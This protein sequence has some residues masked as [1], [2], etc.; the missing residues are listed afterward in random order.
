MVELC[1][2]RG[3]D[4]RQGDI[5]ALPFDDEEFDC[6]LAN[7]VLYHLPDLKLGLSQIARVLRPSGRLVA[8]TYSDDHLCELFKLV[9]RRPDASPFSAD[10]GA[11]SLLRHFNPVE[12]RDVIG[13]ATFPSLDGILALLGA[14]EEF[15]YFAEI[16]L[17][18]RL[19][20]VQ[21]PFHATYRHALFVAHKQG[22]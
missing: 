21:L 8:V 5:Q 17:R 3:L 15:G 7:R 20:D 12:R 1:Q 2:A 4:A 10:N 9:G 11:A 6:V 19:R 14:H 16:D 13:T 18:L 22:D